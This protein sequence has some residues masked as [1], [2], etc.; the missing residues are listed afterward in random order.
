MIRHDGLQVSRQKHVKKGMMVQTFRNGILKMNHLL[1]NELFKRRD[2][3]CSG[4]SRR[5][6]VALRCC[7]KGKVLL[8]THTKASRKKGR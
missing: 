4:G 8:S 2:T 5:S 1:F 6:H 7:W 3:T